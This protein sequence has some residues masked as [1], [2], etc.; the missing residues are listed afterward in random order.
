MWTDAIEKPTLILDPTKCK[1]N[2]QR[3]ASRAQRNGVKFRPHCK[4]HQAAEILEWFR[5]AAVDAITVSSVEM[6]VYFAAHGW[7]D[8]TIAFTVNPRQIKAIN[9]LLA[10]HAGV[11]LGLLVE[12][13]ETVQMLQEQLQHFVHIWIDIDTGY[14]RTG[15][16]WEETEEIIALANA[17]A[18]SPQTMK[19]SGLLGHAGHTYSARSLQQVQSIHNETVQRMNKIRDLLVA[20]GM[21]GLSISIG[22]TPSCSMVEDFGGKID[23]IR[24]GNFVFYDVMQ[25]N[26]GANRL[27]DIA[28][29]VACPVVAKQARLQQIVVFGGAVHLSKDRIVEEPHQRTIFGYLAKATETGWDTIRDSCYVKGL[30]QEHGLIHA[31]NELLESVKIGDILLILP[32]HSCLTANLLKKYHVLNGGGSIS[33]APIPSTGDSSP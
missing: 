20:N 23:E 31:D 6:A 1:A 11:K 2:I 16:D 10:S 21:T 17:V 14:H 18:A 24:P 30:S 3:M 5:S 19:V 12:S 13:M 25:A 8:I 32:V 4:T 9:S 29:A 28:V 26:I 27:S 15:I 33:M 22:D 7:K